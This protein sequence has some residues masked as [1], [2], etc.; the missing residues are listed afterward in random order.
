MLE[1]RNVTVF[2]INSIVELYHERKA[3]VTQRAGG[4]WVDAMQ[5]LRIRDFDMNQNPPPPPPNCETHL[6]LAFIRRC[7]K[8]GTVFFL[9]LRL[10]ETLFKFPH[11]SSKSSDCRPQVPFFSDD[12]GFDAFPAETVSKIDDFV[13]KWESNNIQLA[14]TER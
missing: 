2:H 1:K 14:T 8:F 7:I 9:F 4:S 5:P 10:L 13:G 6:L 12:S 3:G 11:S